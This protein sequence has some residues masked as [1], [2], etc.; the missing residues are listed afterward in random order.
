M[1]SSWKSN[2]G[3]FLGPGIMSILVLVYSQNIKISFGS[4]QFWQKILLILTPRS[5]NS[6]TGLTL[7]YTIHMFFVMVMLQGRLKSNSALRERNIQVRI[8]LK[9]V[10]KFWDVGSLIIRIN[11]QKS[12]LG[13][14]QQPPTENVQKL[15]NDISWF[16]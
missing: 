12:N 7:K 10:L 2:F 6:I 14:P 3:R 15:K 1:K 4:V 9:V 11:F 8:Y 16:H 5:I 13:W